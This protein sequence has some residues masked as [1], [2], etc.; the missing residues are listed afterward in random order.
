MSAEDLKKTLEH[1]SLQ[2]NDIAHRQRE[3]SA[4]HRVAFQL[5]E[6]QATIVVKIRLS[7]PDAKPSEWEHVASLGE[8]IWKYQK[9]VETHTTT[10]KVVSTVIA[11]LVG[12]ASKVF[13]ANAS[14][15][16][17]I[18]VGTGAGIVIADGVMEVIK[19]RRDSQGKHERDP[20]RR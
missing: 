13:T 10:M 5:K 12:I 3:S 7:N 6:I 15:W 20:C 14:L 18:A 8:D 19:S 16:K 1:M 2:L 11:G 9:Q 4:T 17:V